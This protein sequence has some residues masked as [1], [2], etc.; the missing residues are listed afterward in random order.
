VYDDHTGRDW[1]EETFFEI[2]KVERGES[3]ERI[4]FF[5]SII[6]TRILWK[7]LWPYK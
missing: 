2:M 1:D 6:D 3:K 4:N 7:T 5:W